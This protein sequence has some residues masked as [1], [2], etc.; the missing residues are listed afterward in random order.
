MRTS[1]TLALAT[2]AVGPF[3]WLSAILHRRHE[4]I[5]MIGRFQVLVSGLLFFDQ[6]VGFN[7][8]SQRR[9]SLSIWRANATSERRVQDRYTVI[10]AI[11][12]EMSPRT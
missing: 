2:I 10:L 8:T 11:R 9:G 5:A 12:F 6:V 1:Q 3:I 7:G 4:N